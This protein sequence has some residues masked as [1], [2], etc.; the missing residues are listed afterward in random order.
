MLV[1]VEASLLLEGTRVAQDAMYKTLSESQ[2]LTLEHLLQPG[3]SQT[4]PDFVLGS[5]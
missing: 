2:A 1:V 5:A 4:P 3:I